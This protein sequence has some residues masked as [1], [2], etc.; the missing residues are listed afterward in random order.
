V[1]D[2]EG[3]TY[4]ILGLQFVGLNYYRYPFGAEVMEH[5]P[6][7]MHF[8]PPA[9]VIQS[10]N[11]IAMWAVMIFVWIAGIELDLRKIWSFRSRAR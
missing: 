3:Q 7:I 2:L 5:F 11:G 8:V 1:P 6:S 10:L 9:P 4:K